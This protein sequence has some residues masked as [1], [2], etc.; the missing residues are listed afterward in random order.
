M[1]F[2]NKLRLVVPSAR[3]EADRDIREELASLEAIAGRGQLG[4]LTLVAEDARGEMTGSR[5]SV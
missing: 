5:S 3:R 4:N 2:W 1:T